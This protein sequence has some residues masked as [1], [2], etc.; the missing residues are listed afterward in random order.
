MYQ[1]SSTDKQLLIKLIQQVGEEM[2]LA[3]GE[4]SM[5]F[6]DSVSFFGLEIS[7]LELPPSLTINTPDR[8]ATFPSNAKTS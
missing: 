7:Q 5:W 4:N 1:N 2:G 8:D 3:A 6:N